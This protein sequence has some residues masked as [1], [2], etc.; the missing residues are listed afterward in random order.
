[1]SPPHPFA[2][3]HGAVL[4]MLRAACGTWV[5]S[6]YLKAGLRGLD[7]TGPDALR[8]CLRRVRK[9]LRAGEELQNHHG[10]G[11]RIARPE[12]RA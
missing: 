8:D 10:H 2:S 6:R 11:Y 5:S 12:E 9:G 4:R 7:A 1:M 3:H